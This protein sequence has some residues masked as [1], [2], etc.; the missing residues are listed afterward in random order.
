MFLFAVFFYYPVNE[1]SEAYRHSKATDLSVSSCLF[2]FVSSDYGAVVLINCNLFMTV[3]DSMFRCCSCNSYVQMNR[4]SFSSASITGYINGGTFERIC[5]VGCS[6]NQSGFGIESNAWN[7]INTSFISTHSSTG[8]SH[9]FV[10]SKETHNNINI[11]RINGNGIHQGTQHSTACYSTVKFYQMDNSQGDCT[12]NMDCGQY[13]E[14]AYYGN[15]INNSFKLAIF[16]VWGGEGIVDN[17]VFINSGTK[18]YQSYY[19]GY[20]TLTSCFSDGPIPASSFV[21]F[22]EFGTMEM[23]CVLP[24]RDFTLNNNHSLLML[25]LLIAHILL[26]N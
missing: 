20:I 23:N 3:R 14:S 25:S 5:F 7:W 17:F 18:L 8:Y 1:T 22:Y 12:I 26:L 13:T 11:S 24:T 4:V 15:V 2:S 6:G 9:Y 19:N 16:G 10:Y 21:K